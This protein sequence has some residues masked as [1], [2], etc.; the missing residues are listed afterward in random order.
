MLFEGIANCFGVKVLQPLKEGNKTLLNL[1]KNERT[2]EVYFMIDLNKEQYQEIVKFITHF[3]ED[4]A[5]LTIKENPTVF[6]KDLQI[7][8]KIP[9]KALNFKYLNKPKVIMPLYGR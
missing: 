3:D 4:L 8:A 6:P 1:P 2:Q 7:W 5:L 9:N